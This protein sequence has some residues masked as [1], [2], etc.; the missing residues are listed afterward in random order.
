MSTDA[1]N[2][3]HLHNL[4][5]EIV[6]RYTDQP[7]RL[8]AELR[9]QVEAS[10]NG[11][12]VQLYALA[13]LDHALRL[14]QVW[15]ALGPGRLAM[16]R[17]VDRGEQWEIESVERARIQAVR[18]APGLSAT[19]LTILGRPGDVPLAVLRY[20]H[21]QRRAFE[22][23]KFVLEEALEGRSVTAPDADAEYAASVARPMRDAQALVAGR[24]VAVI[25]RL[26]GYLAP[27][28]RQ[29]TLGMAAAT[30]ITLVS[31]V[32]PYLAGY[33]IDR[34]VRPAQEG[35]LDGGRAAMIAWLA[36]AAMALVYVVR[37][38]AALVRLRLMAVLGEWVAR[39]LRAE[40][41]EHLQRLSLAFFSRK[42][43]GSLITRVSADT[44]RLWDFLAFGVVDV[45][46]SLVMLAG[47][48]AVLVSLDWRLGLVMTLPVP[49]FCWAIYRHGEA[50]NRV[51]LRVWRK[52]SR[53]TDV[54]S[55]TMP[56]I[57]VVKAFNQEAREVARFDGHN[58]DVTDEINRL[59]GLVG[60]S[61]GG[62][63]TIVNLIARFY[64]VTGGAIRI[65]GV[66][67]RRLET[68]HYRRQIGMVLQDSYLFHGT[69]LENI[70]YGLPGAS[71]EQAV[72]AAKAAN[73]HD[74]IC[75]LQH[76]YDTVG[77]ERGH[78]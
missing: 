6:A 32:P 70:R 22:N 12:P 77:G 36:V 59:H 24:R 13:D 3:P 71:L 58:D 50:L 27:Y 62:K 64:D 20:S 44:D 7:P 39:D 72:A 43:T 49:L 17:R 42:R 34:V 38:A 2:L 11:A 63:T 52:W 35:R 23:L 4:D 60:P 56:G 55:D 1:H 67:L 37:Q 47:L 40:L 68:G 25:R 15:V 18:E 74:F 66:D 9:R 8:P 5:T 28:R 19:T 51:F 14:T 65:D 45:S 76:G 61:G 46:L 41:Y 26:L 75:K 57:R 73:A 29:L 10:W 33:V 16:A 48:G 53:L 21:R 54:L 30:L 69:V 78:K 31:L